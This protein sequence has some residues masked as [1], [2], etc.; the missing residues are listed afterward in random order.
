MYN[1]FHPAHVYNKVLPFLPLTSLQFPPAVLRQPLL[2]WI[3]RVETQRSHGGEQ[4]RATSKPT[5][6]QSSWKQA[7]ISQ[8]CVWCAGLKI[9]LHCLWEVRAHCSLHLAF[10]Q[11]VLTRHRAG[12]LGWPGWACL[13]PHEENSHWKMKA[14]LCVW[15]F[16]ANSCPGSRLRQINICN[17]A[18]HAP[19]TAAICIGRLMLDERELC[20]PEGK[21]T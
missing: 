12:P 1:D 7:P 16:S 13:C 18:H 14:D 19:I 8:I 10:A 6:R 4:H 5:E 9:T 20:A 21:G 2:S 17:K 15:W 3:W 11:C